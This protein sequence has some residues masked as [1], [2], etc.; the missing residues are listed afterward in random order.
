MKSPPPLA[1][2]IAELLP[3]ARVL[4]RAEAPALVQCSELGVKAYTYPRHFAPNTPQRRALKIVRTQ[5]PRFFVMCAGR[6]GSKTKCG[7]AVFVD[8]VLKDVEDK[9]LGR[10]KWAGFPQPAWVKTEGKDPEPFLRYFVMAPTYALNDEPKIALRKYFGHVKDAEPGLIESQADKP[11]VWWTRPGVR[12]DFLTGDTPDLNVSHGYDGGWLE[13]AARLKPAVYGNIRPALSDKQGWCVVSTTPKGRN[14]LWREMWAKGDAKAAA[15][16][17]KMDSVE[18]ADV[19][20][21]QFVCL[22]WTTADNDALPHLK[23][24]METARRQLPDAVFRREY[25]ADFDAF[26]G[27]VFD[28]EDAHFVSPWGGKPYKRIWAGFDSGWGHRGACSVAIQRSDRSFQEVGT[29]SASRVLPYG[30]EAWARREHGD[31]STW[32]NRMWALLRGVAGDQWHRVP[33]F[34]PADRPDIKQEWERYGFAVE[35]AYQ[36][37]EPAVTWMQTALKNGRFCMQSEAL[38]TCMTA[39]QYPEAGKSSKKLWKDENDDEWDALRYALSE[40]L[41]EGYS[42]LRE[43]TTLAAMGWSSRR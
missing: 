4:K 22:S 9:L 39:L 33:V 20:D 32:A 38:W 11:S 41:R 42:P 16:V 35:A 10:G 28:L 43:G 19:L 37:H 25:L 6:R 1:D 30:D 29:D 8:L 15:L 23:I 36:E 14:W 26:E 3:G 13:E 7:A 12:V 31:R 40:V 5:A 21:P 34:I 2:L 18:V 24:E 17:A 27:Q